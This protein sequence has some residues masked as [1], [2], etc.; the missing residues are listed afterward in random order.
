M[1]HAPLLDPACSPEDT[2][3]RREQPVRDVAGFLAAEEAAITL[4]EDEQTICRLCQIEDVDETSGPLLSPCLC[5]GTVRFAHR[6]CLQRW[7][8]LRPSALSSLYTVH[9]GR[10]GPRCEICHCHYRYAAR[11]GSR[12]EALEQLLLDACRPMSFFLAIGFVAAWKLGLKEGFVVAGCWLGL[13]ALRRHIRCV[14]TFLLLRS[15]ASSQ[16][17]LMSNVVA[18]SL[19]S[20]PDTFEST[21]A[22]DAE[23]R[24]RAA[25]Q[26]AEARWVTGQAQDAT[27]DTDSG[28]NI[29]TLICCVGISCLLLFGAVFLTPFLLRAMMDP[30]LCSAILSALCALGT[31]HTI[32]ASSALLV[33]FGVPEIRSLTERERMTAK[34]ARERQTARSSGLIVGGVAPRFA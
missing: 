11:P 17:A 34:R 16:S 5:D 20:A 29:A 28:G 26:E 10:R 3:L 2:S 15:D 27:L 18:A 1:S 4:T 21:I 32:V 14:A 30:F 25:A 22:A 13:R 33:L 9:S 8:V 19:L 23:E 12:R 24:Y 7:A 31:V 6:T